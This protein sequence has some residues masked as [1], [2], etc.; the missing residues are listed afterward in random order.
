MKRYCGGGES[1]LLASRRPSHDNISIFRQLRRSDGA[2]L[3]LLPSPS[4]NSQPF[5]HIRSKHV[6][7][8][9]RE[10]MQG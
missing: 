10:D 6:E 4:L 9:I 7:T 8:K 3:C 5:L 1:P 2:G